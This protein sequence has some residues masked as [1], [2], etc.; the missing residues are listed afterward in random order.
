MCRTQRG[1]DS[2]RIVLISD[3]Y[4]PHLGGVELQVEALG[5]ALTAQGHDVIV[6]TVWEH[7]RPTGEQNG[8]VRLVRLKSLATIFPWFSGDPARRYHPPF[9]DP[10]IALSLRRLVRRFKPDVV[11]AHGWI[12][13]SAALALTGTGIPMVLSVRDYGYSC[14][15]RNLLIDGSIC[16][17]PQLAKCLRHAA[18]VYGP[19]KGIVAV[20]AVLA[21]RTW[22]GRRVR[23]VHAVSGH[24]ARI[25]QRDLLCGSPAGRVG[26]T[27]NVVIIPDIVLTSRPPSGALV[28]GAL[29]PGE[30][31][32]ESEPD[33]ASSLPTTPFI[34]FVGALQPHKGIWPLLRAYR[35][36][37]DPPPLVLIGTRWPD[38][39]A[40]IPSDVTVLSDVAHADVMRA[41]EAALFGVAPSIWPDPLPGVIREAMSLGKAVVGT[42]VGGIP[43]IIV[44]GENGLLVEPGDEIGLATAMTRLIDDP[45][46]RERLGAQARTD[47]AR[48]DP[49]NIVRWFVEAYQVQRHTD[50]A[51]DG[52]SS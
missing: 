31:A 1:R 30:R 14:A 13:Y 50:R 19:G 24:V 12:A 8:D 21:L 18:K 15:T 37:V 2:M 52:G 33:I 22:L 26:S 10:R 7:G 5:Q 9:P 29:V 36:L 4:P 51:L 48:Y 6:A 45:Q 40:D 23:T 44:D 25:V 17:G 47:V 41:W 3:F 28:T 16:S 38:T 49:A 11:Q 34:L 42:R 32:L 20:T 43:D 39:P 35:T 27:P 46:L